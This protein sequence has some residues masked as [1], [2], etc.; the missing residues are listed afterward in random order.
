MFLVLWG[1]GE[2]ETFYISENSIK[3][4]FRAR[5]VQIWSDGYRETCK[6][7]PCIRSWIY[8]RAPVCRQIITEIQRK[9]SFTVNFCDLRKK[10]RTYA[11]PFFFVFFFVLSKFSEMGHTHTHTHVQ[12]NTF[13]HVGRVGKLFH[14]RQRQYYIYNI[15]LMYKIYKNRAPIALPS[16]YYNLWYL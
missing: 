1:W 14:A 9:C 3:C 8:F 15:F 11:F 5:A 6:S 12:V 10:L 2:R 13:P 16:P 4:I 7:G